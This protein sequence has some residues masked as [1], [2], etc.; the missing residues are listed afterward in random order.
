MSTGVKEEG[1]LHGMRL[2][3]RFCGVQKEPCKHEI[4]I[5]YAINGAPKGYTKVEMSEIT[6]VDLVG[7]KKGH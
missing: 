4:G 2:F 6:R 5:V 7:D 1:V 3:T